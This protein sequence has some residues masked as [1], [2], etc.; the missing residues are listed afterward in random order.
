MPTMR[1]L[2][3]LLGSVALF[4]CRRE[5]DDGSKYA[6]VAQEAFTK[7]QS[8]P[9]DRVTVTPR[10]DLDAFDLD[11]GPLPDPPKEIASD[12]GRLAQWK[13]DKGKP[14]CTP[15]GNALWQTTTVGCMRRV[16]LARGCGHQTY[17]VCGGGAHAAG[18]PAGAVSDSCSIARHPPP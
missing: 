7:E 17:Y 9:R 5:K 2:L 15:E 16:V 10:P 11:N 4:G 8:C 12:P 6:S 13:K 14:D 3:V 18:D 1:T